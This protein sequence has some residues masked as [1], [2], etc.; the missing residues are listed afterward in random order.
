MKAY[1]SQTEFPADPLPL[2]YR[3][4]QLS[5]PERR[6]LERQTFRG[7]YPERFVETGDDAAKA[8]PSNGGE[9]AI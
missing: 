9:V 5:W 4:L 3:M 1:F 6:E 2:W 8:A 7:L